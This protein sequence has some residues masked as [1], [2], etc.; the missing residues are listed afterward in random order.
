MNNSTADGVTAVVPSAVSFP[1]DDLFYVGPAYPEA[2]APVLTEPTPPRRGWC[3]RAGALGAR[4]ARASFQAFWLITLLAVMTALPVVQL[5]AFGYLLDVAGRLTQGRTIREALDWLRPAGQLGLAVLA[6]FLVSLPIGLLGHLATVGEV[7]SPGSVEARNL[8]IGAFLL[9]VAGTIYLGW[10]WA[11]GGRWWHYLWPQPKRFLRE[12]WRP[13]LWAAAADRFWDWMVA[14]RVGGR[15]WLGLRGAVA[16]LVWL[17]PATVIISANRHG[18]TGLAGLV[19]GIAFVMLG[20]ALLYLPMLQ[21]NFAAQG[22]VRAMFEVR[23]IRRDFRRAPWAW[24][25]A[26]TLTLVFLPI[27]LYLLKIE[28]PPP[29]LVWLPTW[30]F[31]AFMLPARIACGLALRR[32]RRLPDPQGWLAGLSRWSAR[33]LCVPVVAV[34]LLFVFLS[35]FTSWDGLQTWVHQHAVLVPA[36]FVLR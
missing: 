3:R 23:R 12:A 14:W 26:M 19:G 20:V 25:T 18:T 30:M 32:A 13:S 6:T 10:A 9:V 7:I 28:P 24:L 22:R 16:T 5:I 34:Y 11:R 33:L 4:G 29:E 1:E 2:E 21:A 31:I 27:P 15:F 8:R 35:Q 36:P 17:V